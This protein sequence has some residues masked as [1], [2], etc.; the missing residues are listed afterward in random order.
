MHFG[1]RAPGAPRPI[2]SLSPLRD[3]FF[4]WNSRSMVENEPKVANAI[5]LKDKGDFLIH[6]VVLQNR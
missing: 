6:R 4:G 5:S 1:E 2:W 3:T